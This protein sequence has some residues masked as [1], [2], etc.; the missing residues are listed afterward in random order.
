MRLD[1]FFQ[2]TDIVANPVSF[3]LAANDKSL[4]YKSYDLVPSDNVDKLK[5][6]VRSICPGFP[7]EQND[8]TNVV[9]VDPSTIFIVLFGATYQMD[10]EASTISQ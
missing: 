2:C 7:F 6:N 8:L 5:E 3:E 10:K 1:V 9:F 4:L